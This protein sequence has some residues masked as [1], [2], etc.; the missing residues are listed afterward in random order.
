M[1]VSAEV[2]GSAGVH[3]GQTDCPLS[4]ARKL[5]GPDAIIGISTSTPEEAKKA[6]EDGADYIGIGAVWPTQSKDLKGKQVLGPDG[7]GLVLDALSEQDV[8]AVAIGESMVGL[9]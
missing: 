4:L 6:A 9:H 7:V 5:L 1:Y 3:L 8:P 2:V